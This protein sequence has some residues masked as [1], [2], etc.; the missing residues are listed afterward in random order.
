MNE[1]KRKTVAVQYSLE[2]LFILRLTSTRARNYVLSKV[3]V[4]FLIFLE[5]K[6][7]ARFG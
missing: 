3:F 7:A 4:C 2:D 6:Y 1:K 5:K